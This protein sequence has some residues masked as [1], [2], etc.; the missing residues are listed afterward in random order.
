MET[1]YT[2]LNAGTFSQPD[3]EQEKTPSADHADEEKIRQENLSCIGH[4]NI[5]AYYDDRR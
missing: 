1:E 4:I 5:Q 3:E 2:V